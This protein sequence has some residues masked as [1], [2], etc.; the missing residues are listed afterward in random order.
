LCLKC[1]VHPAYEHARPNFRKQDGVG[2]ESCHGAA[3]DW[4]TP[5]YRAGWQQADHERLGFADIKRL[6]GRAEICAKCHVGTPEANVD[7]DLIAAGHPALRFEFATYFANLP[8]HWDAARDKKENST[9]DAPT[10]DFEMRA[11]SAGQHAALACSLDLLAYRADPTNGKAWPEFAELDCFSCHHDLSG[12]GWRQKKE[13]L[14]ARADQDA[15]RPGSFLWNQW[16]ARP[17]GMLV[18]PSRAKI[19]ANAAVYAKAIRDGRQRLPFDRGDGKFDW[20]DQKFAAKSHTWD[21]TTQHYLLLLAVRQFHKDNQRP[22]DANLE[23][24]IAELRE[25]VTFPPAYNSPRGFVP[26]AFRL[27]DTK[28]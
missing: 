24:R 1:H 16:Y 13:H 15:R 23:R 4:L 14:Q 8:P 17:P 9:R 21:E 26:P 6:R 19:A 7:H 18:D 25:Q 10:I 12:A 5:H 3:Q 22:P 28:K 20:A 11:W 2:C 27:I